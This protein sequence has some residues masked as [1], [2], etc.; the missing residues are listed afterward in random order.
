[1]LR[2]RRRD[3]ML[4]LLFLLVEHSLPIASIQPLCRG[5]LLL[6]LGIL[7]GHEDQFLQELPSQLLQTHLDH[8]PL[9]AAS[10]AMGP[11]LQGQGRCMVAIMVIM[12]N[13]LIAEH[14]ILLAST[15]LHLGIPE[16]SNI[17]KYVE[18]LIFSGCIY[19]LLFF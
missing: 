5:L 7:Q 18:G 15:H 19:V 12:E 16:H 17:I 6:L 3:K 14:H 13:T 9:Q 1:M 2:L 4:L 11:L 10:R 8:L